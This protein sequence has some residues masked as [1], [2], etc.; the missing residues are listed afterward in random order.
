MRLVG[1]SGFDGGALGGG[2]NLPP[3]PSPSGK[4]ESC[5]NTVEGRRVRE[6]RGGE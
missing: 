1:P 6:G 2:F 3:S 4:R 5:T